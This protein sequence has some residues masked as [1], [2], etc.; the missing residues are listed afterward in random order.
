MPPATT[1]LW[2]LCSYHAVLSAAQDDT[3][4]TIYNSSRE[5]GREV[6]LNAGEKEIVCNY[7][8][9]V[10]DK[11]GQG[12]AIHILAD[13]PVGAVQLQDGDGRDMTAF[14][15]SS[16][17]KS[18]F[19]IPKNSQYI[20]VTCPSENTDVTLYRPDGRSESQNCSANGNIPGKAYF[21]NGDANG[22][23]IVQ[24]SYLES[25]NPIHLIYEVTGTEDEHNLVGAAP[26][27]QSNGFFSWDVE[28]APVGELNRRTP[29]QPFNDVNRYARITTDIVDTVPGDSCHSGNRCMRLG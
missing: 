17:L 15:P 27:S 8:A 6:T 19:G 7:A 9:S 14:Y 23:H 10:E 5:S 24:G 25:S 28:N 2:G 3:Y 21:G 22:T 16:L 18:R 29:N 4:V 13:K 20:A 12:P 1:E 26:H 11:Q